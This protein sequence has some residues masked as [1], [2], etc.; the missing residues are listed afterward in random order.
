MGRFQFFFLPVLDGS[1]FASLWWNAGISLEK[2]WRLFLNSAKR[3]LHSQDE[4][5]SLR[6]PVEIPCRSDASPPSKSAMSQSGFSVPQ[7]GQA[8]IRKTPTSCSLKLRDAQP[9][10]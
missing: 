2:R 3:D 7:H 5:V 4:P 9:A 8:L 6:L 10:S 1:P